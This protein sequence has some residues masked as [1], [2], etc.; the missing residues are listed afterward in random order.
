MRWPIEDQQEIRGKQVPLA[1]NRRGK[2]GRTELL[3]G[4][5]EHFEVVSGIESQL[6]EQLDSH[7][8]LNHRPL[9]IRCRA[10]KHAPFGIK[11]FAQRVPR[12]WPPLSQL[13]T[14]L[15][16]GLVRIVL[17]PGGWIHGLAVS[18]EI[19][20]HGTPRTLNEALR[21]QCRATLRL[22]PPRE[23]DAPQDS[24]RRR[25]ESRASTLV[26][27]AFSPIRPTRQMRPASLPRPPPTSMP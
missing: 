12:E 7:Q 3:L 10:G 17:V 16:N 20:Q 25:A 18:L 5:D 15:E 4:I 1:R 23:A 6:I 2:M 19:N 21:I 8:E 22:Q 14:L 13:V 11:A 24:S 9:G 27:R 26:R